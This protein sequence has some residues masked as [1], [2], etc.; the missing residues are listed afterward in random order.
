MVG[1]NTGVL[2]YVFGHPGCVGAGSAWTALGDAF[3][4]LLAAA[5]SVA[6]LALAGRRLLGWAG[7]EADW[8]TALGLGLGAAGTTL[9]LTGLI[10]GL[11]AGV[12]WCLGA[13]AGCLAVLGLL[14]RKSN[15]ALPVSRPAHAPPLREG[16]LLGVLAFTAWHV[17]VSALAPPTQWD[18]LAYHLALPKLYLRAGKILHVPWM[19]HSHWPHL[20]ETL[21][22]VPLALGIDTAAGLLHAAVCGA[23]IL[24]VHRWACPRLGAR[25]AFLASALLAAQPVVNRLAGTA[26]SDGGQ[27]LF[28]FLSAAWLWRWAEE[29]DLRMLALAGL[30]GGLAAA[31]KLTGL[32]LTASLAA[33]AALAAPGRKA[34][35]RLKAAALYLLCAGILCVPWYIKTGLATGDPFWPFLDAWLGGSAK[36]MVAAYERSAFWSFPRDAG[37]I[38]HNGPQFLLLPFAGLAVLARLQGG[39]LPRELSFLLTVSLAY[40]LVIC[41]QVEAWRFSMAVFPALALC[42]GWAADALLKGGTL[43]RWGAVEAGGRAPRPPSGRALAGRGAVEAGGRAPRAPLGGV[44]ARWGAALGL[45]FG[46]FPPLALTQNNELFPVLGLRSLIAPGRPSREVYLERSLDHYSFFRRAASRLPSGSRVLLFREIRGYYLDAD[47]QWGDP[48]NQMV[49]E[50]RRLGPEDLRSRLSQLGAT[51]VLVNEG[52]GMYAQREGYYDRRVM[53]AMAEVLRCCATPVV[54]EGALTLW[55]V[56][57]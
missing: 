57:N 1:R 40:F 52:I 22:T 47:Y 3:L 54:K 21:Y 51:H 46:L 31:C 19:I 8:F 20:M 37:L 53:G 42:A 48:L 5:F 23:W 10:I 35:P 55:S 11:D 41:R 6:A 2:R 36:D 39:R 28:F 14:G 30:F 43:P 7:L 56:D 29:D 9:L 18:V 33:W 27:A 38:L 16:V 49:I 34:G 24:A 26:H 32:V 15:R 45:A 13:A 12:F 50:Y 4:P 44:W 17:L 25:A